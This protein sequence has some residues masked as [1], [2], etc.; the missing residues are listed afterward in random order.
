[1]NIVGSKA[2]K[3]KRKSEIASR[4]KTGQ[5][6]QQIAYSMDLTDRMVH[7]YLKEMI[8]DGVLERR[9]EKPAPYGPHNR[10]SVRGASVR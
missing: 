8:E 2:E 4:Y 10:A 7:R 5:S 1:M 9:V 6:A 3:T